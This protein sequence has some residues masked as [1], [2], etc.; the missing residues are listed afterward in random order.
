[1][2]DDQHP[3]RYVASAVVL[4]WLVML[5]V[6]SIDSGADSGSGGSGGRQSTSSVSG[7]RTGSGDGAIERDADAEPPSIPAELDG[8]YEMPSANGECDPLAGAPENM[9]LYRMMQDAFRH[10]AS[11]TP[12]LVEPIR[13]FCVPSKTFTWGSLIDSKRSG[14]EATALAYEITAEQAARDHYGC[15]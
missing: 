15:E 6:G 8:W 4:A 12:D 14:I 13:E 1:M 7:E 5:V 9:R 11:C 2:K 10:A 3:V